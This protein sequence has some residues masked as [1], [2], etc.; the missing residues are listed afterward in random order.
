ML[1]VSGFFSGEKPRT[2]SIRGSGCTT[3]VDVQTFLEAS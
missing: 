1:R 2:F 3:T